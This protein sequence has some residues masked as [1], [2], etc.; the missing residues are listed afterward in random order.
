MIN[1]ENQNIE[2]SA[3]DIKNWCPMFGLPCYD[4]QLTEPF[5]MSFVQTVI[6]CKDIG[7]KFAVSEYEVIN[8]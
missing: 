4:R 8:P 7:L 2:I 3:E 1:I 6:Y 5:F